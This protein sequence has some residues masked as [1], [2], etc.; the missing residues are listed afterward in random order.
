MK[1]FKVQARQFCLSFLICLFLVTVVQADIDKININ[2][3]TAQEL[4]ILKRIGPSYAS[5][6]IEYR[7]QNGDYLLPEDIMPLHLIILV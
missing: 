2:T 4:A 7:E 3:A 6:I 5:R 1:Q